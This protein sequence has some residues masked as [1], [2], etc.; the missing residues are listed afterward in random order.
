[1]GDDF[2]VPGLHSLGQPLAKGEQDAPWPCNADNKYIV[3]FPETREI[4]SY[5]SG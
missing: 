1:L 5:G 3:H 4:M 2:F